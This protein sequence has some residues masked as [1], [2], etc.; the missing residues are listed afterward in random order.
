ML[1]IFGR[2]CDFNGVEISVTAS[3]DQ[4]WVAKELFF[5]VGHHIRCPGE[6]HA[7]SQEEQGKWCL[8]GMVAGVIVFNGRN[9]LQVQLADWKRQSDWN[10][11]DWLTAR[12]NQSGHTQ[13]T[14]IIHFS[15]SAHLL[16]PQL[17]HRANSSIPKNHSN[18]ISSWWFQPIWIIVKLD[19]FPR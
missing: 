19:H 5:K 7:D 14:G 8:V 2:P 13:H 4:S 12:Q 17:F 10:S 9:V 3:W 16:S 6:E 15:V 1:N 18:W 11:V